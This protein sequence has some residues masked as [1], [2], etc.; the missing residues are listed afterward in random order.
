MQILA[1]CLYRIELGVLRRPANAL[2]V[3]IGAPAPRCK[4]KPVP[5]WECRE[6]KSGP[7]LVFRWL[8][9]GGSPLVLQK[10]ESPCPKDSKE[11]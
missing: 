1:Q 8:A 5:E 11:K 2:N 3:E 7:S 9:S 6:P 10:C 4:L